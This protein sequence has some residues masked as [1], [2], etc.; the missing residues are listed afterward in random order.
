MRIVPVIDLMEGIV[1]HALKGERERYQPVQSILTSSAQP[2]EVARRLQMETSCGALYI[3]DLDAI[4]GKGQNTEAIGE[5]AAHIDADL[6][7]DAG[8]A[9]VES[10]DRL[11][12]A[13]ADIV[14]IGSE[15]LTTMQQLR[16]IRDSIARDKLILSLDIV[17]GRVRSA[18]ESLKDL[19]PL[20]ALERLVFEGLECF[21]LLTL[22]AVGTG[23]GPDLPLLDRAKRSFPRLTLI[24]GGGVKTPEH[25]RALSATKVDGVLVATS[26]HRGWIAGRDIAA[27]R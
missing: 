7:V 22:D 13:G 19:E 23:G 4:Q 24:A 8:T 11:L 20:E 18:A 3:A 10:A 27:L 26:L 17:G 14:I 1:V 15:T 16:R 2:V 21:I 9:D 25:L 5:I 12:T 6:W